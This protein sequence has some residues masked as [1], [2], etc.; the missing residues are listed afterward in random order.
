[1][2]SSM[3][4]SVLARVD[5]MPFFMELTFYQGK[6]I[7]QMSVTMSDINERPLVPLGIGQETYS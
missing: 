7:N 3:L 5:P 2:S 1:M 6:H 4:D